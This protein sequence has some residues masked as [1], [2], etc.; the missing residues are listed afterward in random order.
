MSEE[1]GV[2]ELKE[3]L[4]FG[5]AMV[6]M[7]VKASADKKIDLN[8]LQLLLT[9]VPTVGPAFEGLDQAKLEIGNLSAEEAAELVAHAMAKLAVEDAKARAIVEAALKAAAANY[10]L[11]VAIKASKAA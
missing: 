1:M 4:D 10:A 5:L 6:E 9:V 3:I 7:G 8:D 11:F 2:K